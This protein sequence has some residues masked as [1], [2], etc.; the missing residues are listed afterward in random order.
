VSGFGLAPLVQGSSEVLLG[1][2]PE[3][4][5]HASPEHLAGARLEARSDVYSLGAIL[6]ELATGTPPF[7]AG[8]G[9]LAGPAS[10]RDPEPPSRRRGSNE[11]AFRVFDKIVERC[12]KRAPEQRYASAAELAADLGR[13][14][15]A[16]GRA[17]AASR[18]QQAQPGTPRAS[19]SDARRR[20]GRPSA[21]ELSPARR[22]P[23]KAVVSML[24]LPKVIVQG[25]GAVSAS[26]RSAP[27]A[28][29]RAQPA[30][31]LRAAGLAR[32]FR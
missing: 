6:Y 22:P 10:R 32:G 12:L 16:L 31:S 1:A 18:A 11:L 21:V 17:L 7:G 20:N 26:L 23:R 29:N 5:R 8:A 28:S 14:E 3:A 4:R 27:S 9:A 25:G 19:S 2:G 13:L 30:R 15:A 24:E